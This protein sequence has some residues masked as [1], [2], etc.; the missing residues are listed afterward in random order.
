[1]AGD[2]YE[3]EHDQQRATLVERIRGERREDVAGWGAKSKYIRSLPTGTLSFVGVNQV[4]E[5]RTDT[6]GAGLVVL[7]TWQ[8]SLKMKRK[9]RDSNGSVRSHFL[10]GNARGGYI[11]Y[12]PRNLIIYLLSYLVL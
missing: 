5:Y 1:M 6:T 8:I 9:S 2:T 12:P 3:A 11:G 4:A 10:L 7:A